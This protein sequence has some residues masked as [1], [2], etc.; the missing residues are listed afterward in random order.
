MFPFQWIPKL[1]IQVSAADGSK[2]LI[3]SQ[4]NPLFFAAKSLGISWMMN[5]PP[6]FSDQPSDFARALE[7]RRWVIFFWRL[8]WAP[9]GTAVPRKKWDPAELI[10]KKWNFA[11]QIIGTSPWSPQGGLG[12]KYRKLG[13]WTSGKPNWLREKFTGNIRKPWLWPT[14]IKKVL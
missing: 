14:R 13:W 11:I 12:T 1:R 10:E 9:R 5:F 3:L 8:N 4:W 2:V 7:K 6:W